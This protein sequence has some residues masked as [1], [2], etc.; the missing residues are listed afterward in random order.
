[1][2]RL[3]KAR[4]IKSRWNYTVAEVAALLG[5]A[6][7]TVRKWIKDGL[8]LATDRRPFLI[9]GCDLKAFLDRRVVSRKQPLGPGQIFCVACRAP[10][11]PAGDMADYAARGPNCG[12][13]IGICPDCHRVIR[14]VVS[15]AAL[16]FTAA[17]LD[18][19]IRRAV[20]TLGRATGPCPNRHFLT[21][22][23]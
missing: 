23:S 6:R 5:V 16:D 3:A 20:E 15:W 14:R 4:G 11:R 1:M 12:T 9:R 19:S 17:G 7:N 2:P 8:P 18:L 10:K 21:G 13:L 22:E